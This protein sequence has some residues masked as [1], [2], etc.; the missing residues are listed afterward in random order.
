MVIIVTLFY[1]C[2][3]IDHANHSSTDIINATNKR[4]FVRAQ[5]ARL[6]LALG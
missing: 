1:P 6:D 3:N 4:I 5:D 2:G